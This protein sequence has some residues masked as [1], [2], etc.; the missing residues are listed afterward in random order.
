MATRDVA[1]AIGEGLFAGLV[2]TAAMTL[3]STLEAKVR[4]RGP[5]RTPAEAV[6]EVFDL[7]PGDDEAEQRLAN[8]THWGYGTAWG[9]V[10]GLLTLTRLSPT[11]RAALH[12]GLIWGAELL[13]LPRLGVV[14]PVKEWGAKEVGLDAA[15]HVVYAGATTAALRAIERTGRPVYVG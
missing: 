3:V 10:G 13:M 8:V 11:A 2:G 12:F 9:A 15:H 5:S 6:E 7:E 1:T 14:P 4:G